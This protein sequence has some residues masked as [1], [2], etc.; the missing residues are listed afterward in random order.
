MTT[1]RVFV[2]GTLKRGFRAHHLLQDAHFLGNAITLPGHAL[3]HLGAYP[4]LIR[5]PG[6]H[7]VHG[8]VF[9][10]STRTLKALDT[11]EG[12]PTLYTRE[13]IPLQDRKG[14]ILAYF[15]ASLADSNSIILDGFW[16]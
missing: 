3:L 9:E 11:Y 15:Y 16:K 13:C 4:G 14:E 10:V 5:L 6:P 7:Q 8:E 1:H 12:T 2:Y